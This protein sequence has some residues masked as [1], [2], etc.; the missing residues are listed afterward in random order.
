MDNTRT[1][2]LE[3]AVS[4]DRAEQLANDLGHQKSRM[5]IKS[6]VEEYVGSS[7]FAQRV[8][9]IQLEMLESTETYKKIDGKVQSQID[10]TLNARNLKNRNFIVPNI[11]AGISVIVA[12]GAVI[13]AWMK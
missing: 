10:A 4:G 5:V 7:Q 8:K 13:V 12:L 11:I 1:T 9:A 6:V 2:L 3:H